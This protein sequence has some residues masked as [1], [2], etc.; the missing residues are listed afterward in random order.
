MD[1]TA[2]E[3]RIGLAWKPFGS[4]TTS[5]RAGYA[6]FHDSS[7]NQGA[8]G[9][10]EKPSV[11]CRVGQF[12]WSLS[13]QQFRLRHPT[14]LWQPASIPPRHYGT[15][16]SPAI[17]GSASGQNLNFK[18][19][20]VQQ[21][22]LNIE[23][24]LPG[25]NIVMTAGYAGSRSSHILVDGLN[26]NVGSPAACGGRPWVHARLRTRRN[27]LCAEVGISNLPIP[28]DNE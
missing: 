16:E 24:Q 8:Q 4:P 12:L 9:T 10:W 26:L 13:L 5:V 22:N 21:F 28:A 1:K 2:F 7:W 3:P 25:G 20:R 23:H 18:Q 6:I 19:G 14:Q 27:C 17:S 15:P 11:L